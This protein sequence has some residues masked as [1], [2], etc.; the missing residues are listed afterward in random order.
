MWILGD[1]LAVPALGLAEGPRKYPVR[2]HVHRLGSH[3]AYGLAA[4]F[5]TSALHRMLEG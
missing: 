1:E 2:Q 4:A 3:L 5:T